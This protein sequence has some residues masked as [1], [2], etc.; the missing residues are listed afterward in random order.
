MLAGH[1]SSQSNAN[2][3]RFGKHAQLFFDGDGH[4]C[5]ARHTVYQL[6]R[7]RVA[8]SREDERN[9][10]VFYG[11]TDPQVRASVEE[12]A[13]L[14]LGEAEDYDFLAHDG[15]MSGA[16]DDAQAFQHMYAALSTLGPSPPVLPAR[17]SS[18]ASPPSAC[19][20]VPRAFGALHFTARCSFDS[21]F[22]PKPG[23][24]LLLFFSFLA[25][26]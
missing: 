2:S 7:A 20:S 16:H 23:T 13:L 26:A 5:G 25:Q 15:C 24:V 12:V 1:A 17:G 4:L 6:E 22:P 8:W 18:V 3:S 19:S 21:R 9:F 14:Q 10:H 11:M